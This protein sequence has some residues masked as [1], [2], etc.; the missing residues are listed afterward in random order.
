MPKRIMLRLIIVA[1]FLSSSTLLSQTQQESDTLRS[2]EDMIKAVI[3]T[4]IKAYRNRDLNG[5]MALWVKNEDVLKVTT[6]GKYIRG[7]KALQSRYATLF[8]DPDFIEFG[9]WTTDTD[10]FNIVFHDDLVWVVHQQQD[11]YKRSWRRKTMLTIQTRILR[12]IGSQW[13]ILFHQTVEL[14]TKRR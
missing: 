3:E 4:Q 8:A 5:E 6:Q 1:F 10:N 13:K 9:D 2:D 12:K 7:W 14:P 11:N